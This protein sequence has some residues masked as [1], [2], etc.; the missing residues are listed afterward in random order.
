MGGGSLGTSEEVLCGRVC[1]SNWFSMFSIR[2]VPLVGDFILAWIA[3]H[4]I[5]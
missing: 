3:Q 5:D 2:P 4:T 1:L